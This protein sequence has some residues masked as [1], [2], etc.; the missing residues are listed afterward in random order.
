MS[1]VRDPLRAPLSPLCARRQLCRA[2]RRAPA[3]AALG[4]CSSGGAVAAVVTCE[5][6]TE[7]VYGRMAQRGGCP[8]VGDR[9]RSPR[10]DVRRFY[11]FSEIK[12]LR[13]CVFSLFA[14]HRLADPGTGRE[15]RWTFSPLEAAYCRSS[16]RPLG[17]GMGS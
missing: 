11:G 13:V 17:R 3:A 12:D 2:P 14:V 16:A 4:C 8:Y 5:R 1:G 15:R 9:P 6:I 7:W 10:P